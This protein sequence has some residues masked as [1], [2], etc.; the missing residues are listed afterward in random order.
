MKTAEEAINMIICNTQGPQIY[1]SLRNCVNNTYNGNISAF[2]N[3]EYCHVQ[4]G[5]LHMMWKERNCVKRLSYD[6]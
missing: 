3:S 6:L 5:C 4:D 2:M 1:E